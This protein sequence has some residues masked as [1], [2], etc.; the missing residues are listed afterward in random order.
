MGAPG[1]SADVHRAEMTSCL[2]GAVS[3][4][5]H[6]LG[7]FIIYI[8]RRALLVTPSRKVDKS[9]PE[10]EREATPLSALKE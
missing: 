3:A 5:G 6:E 4:G 2:Y 9:L 8:H 10:V 1:N 7:S